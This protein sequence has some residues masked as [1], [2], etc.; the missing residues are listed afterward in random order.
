MWLAVP[1]HERPAVKA[2]ALRRFAEH[3]DPDGSA[4]FTVVARYTL[5]AAPH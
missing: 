1:E 4:T 3:A 5:A 2:E